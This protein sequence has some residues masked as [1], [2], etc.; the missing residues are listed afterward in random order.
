MY[1]WDKKNVHKN[2]GKLDIIGSYPYYIKVTLYDD[3][4]FD[5]L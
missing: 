3:T 5:N 4:N 1:C 2:V